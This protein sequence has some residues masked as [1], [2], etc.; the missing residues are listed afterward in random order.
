MPNAAGKYVVNR[1]GQW[2]AIRWSLYDFQAYPAAGTTQ[3]TYFQTQVGSGGRTLSD[4]NMQLSSQIMQGQMFLVES[5][6]IAFW[7]TT[8]TGANAAYLPAAFGADAAPLQVNDEYIFMRS[9][10]LVFTIGSKP[11]LQEAPMGRF[12]A[13][14]HFDLSAAVG[15]QTT[16]AAALQTRVAVGKMVGRPYLLTPYPV[17]LDAG[18]SF[19]IQLTWPEGLQA[20]NAPARVQVI[21]D[22]V[23]FRLSQ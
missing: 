6:E 10:N 23:L 7:P 1:A 4:T 9:G 12:P 3:L 8:P 20:I 15:S 22:G 11:Y 19:Q 5:V 17:L 2:E 18:Q 14:S 16:P 13:K 21:L